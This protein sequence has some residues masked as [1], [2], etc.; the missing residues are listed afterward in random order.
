MWA[1][2]EG[3][4]NRPVCNYEETHMP[5]ESP[6]PA[7]LEFDPGKVKVTEK[8]DLRTGLSGIASIGDDLWLACDEGCRLERLSRSTAAPQHFASHASFG[9]ETLLDLPAAPTEEADIEGMDVDDG[10]LWLVGS[11]SSKRKLPDENDTAPK[12]AEKLGR[13]PKRD[14]NR[15]LLARIPLDG[16]EP[17]KSAAGRA[18]GSIPRTDK[19]SALL[20]A[21]VA[22]QDPHLAPFVGIPG[23]DNGLDIEGLAVRGSRVFVGLRGPVLREW[24]CLLELRSPR[25]V[26]RARPRVD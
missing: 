4:A 21:I 1:I 19:S 24:T 23:K 12:I 20:D 5:D 18:A 22:S 26:R 7:T 10:F 25:R 8:A 15:H 13:V 2:E 6:I 11:H 9:L 17:K 16:R 14:G 3:P